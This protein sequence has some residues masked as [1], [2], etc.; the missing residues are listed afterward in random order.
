M[1]GIAQWRRL[2]VRS[3]FLFALVRM[4]QHVKSFSIRG[5]QSIFDSVVN[6]LHEVPC[7]RGTTVQVTFSRSACISSTPRS[8]RYRITSGRECLEDRIEMSNNVL[9][10]SD[11]LAITALQT[12]NAATRTD[13][14][15]MNAF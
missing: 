14:D 8:C 13:V 10:T 2:G 1:F 15:I 6:H 3:P 9:L 11:H 4:V 12:P 5:H 7:A